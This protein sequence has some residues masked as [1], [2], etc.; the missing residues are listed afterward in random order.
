MYIEAASQKLKQS[1]AKHLQTKGIHYP[2][3][4]YTFKVVLVFLKVEKTKRENLDFACSSYFF[5]LSPPSCIGQKL[6]GAK[7]C[8]TCTYQTAALLSK[9]F[10]FQFTA[11]CEI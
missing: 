7:E 4:K 8:S 10:L 5:L 3:V 11:T 6:K 1:N 9:M 2:I